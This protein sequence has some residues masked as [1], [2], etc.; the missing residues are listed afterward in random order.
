MYSEEQ[1]LLSTLYLKEKNFL[2]LGLFDYIDFFDQAQNNVQSIFK[3]ST[4]KAVL[5]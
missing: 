2:L 4:Y 5:D 3:I 1:I